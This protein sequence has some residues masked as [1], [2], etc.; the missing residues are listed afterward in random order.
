MDDLLTGIHR[1][2]VGIS[3]TLANHHPDS[4]QAYLAGPYVMWMGSGVLASWGIRW[5]FRR[6][7]GSHT[8]AYVNEE[9]VA[10]PDIFRAPDGK[11][12]RTVR[13]Y[14][15]CDGP[16]PPALQSSFQRQPAGHFKRQA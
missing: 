11:W 13:K 12:L 10:G 1:W 6:L 9:A 8:R 15:E 7:F 3:V 14:E 2:M 5:L 16:T 4:Q